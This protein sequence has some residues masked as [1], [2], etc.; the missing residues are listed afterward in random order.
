MDGAP[1]G[2]LFNLGRACDARPPVPGRPEPLSALHRGGFRMRPHE[3]GSRQWD[4]GACSD[5]PRHAMRPGGRGPDLP[6]VRFA[7]QPRDATPGSVSRI[8]SGRRPLL[9]QDA[10]RIAYIRYVVKI[11]LRIVVIILVAKATRK[12]PGSPCKPCE[13]RNRSAGMRPVRYEQQRPVI[14]SATRSSS[15]SRSCAWSCA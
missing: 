7:P 11:F 8:V 4:T 6:T 3:A 14:A 5:C 13:L 9:S 1:T 12:R 2:A 15:L 10:I